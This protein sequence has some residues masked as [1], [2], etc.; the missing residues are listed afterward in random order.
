[1]ADELEARLSRLICANWGLIHDLHDRAGDL[2]KETLDA[3]EAAVQDQQI[4][5]QPK[6]QPAAILTASKGWSW[7][8]ALSSPDYPVDYLSYVQVQFESGA[9]ELQVVVMT[10]YYVGRKLSGVSGQE[11][12]AGEVQA[13]LDKHGGPREPGNG[14]SVAL[15]H[16]VVPHPDGLADLKT[17]VLD[18]IKYQLPLAVI[19]RDAIVRQ[20]PTVNA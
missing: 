18:E 3:V 20:K 1:M 15:L 4:V 7:Y 17:D 5:S 2:R 12:R 8:I 19:I 14:R 6:Y 11:L 16:R 13:W 9:S 10:G